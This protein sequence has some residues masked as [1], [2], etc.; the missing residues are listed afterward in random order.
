MRIE[1]GT[2]TT[3]IWHLQHRSIHHS[4]EYPT[5]ENTLMQWPK[6]ERSEIESAFSQ[7]NRISSDF[8]WFS[9]LD[10]L[11]FHS[12]FIV[13]SFCFEM[14]Q[15]GPISAEACPFHRR[16]N[17]PP[18]IQLHVLPGV[19]VRVC[20]KAPNLSIFEHLWTQSLWHSVTSTWGKENEGFQYVRHTAW[21]LDQLQTMQCPTAISLVV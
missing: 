17:R 21:L 14:A 4:S 20:S 13:L 2:I 16:P 8:I 15:F 18:S 6:P 5:C 7:L 3:E 11:W 9:F 1:I 19:A 12:A 10:I